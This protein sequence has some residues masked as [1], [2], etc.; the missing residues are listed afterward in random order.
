MLCQ[1]YIICP[2]SLLHYSYNFSTFVLTLRAGSIMLLAELLAMQAAYQLVVNCRM[3]SLY[4]VFQGAE[5]K[6]GVCEFG[7]G[8]N[9][10]E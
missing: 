4:C 5:D 1:F 3:A 8:E 9:K 2:Q 7:T 6:L 10:G